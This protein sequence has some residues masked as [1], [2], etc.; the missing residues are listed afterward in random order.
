MRLRATAA[1]HVTREEYD[2][3]RANLLALTARVAVL[4]Q[5]QPARPLRQ[6]DLAIL[7]RLLP[8]L[9]ATY[10]EDGFTSRDCAEDDA[11]GL[12][13]V[14]GQMSV[15]AIGKLLARANGIAIDGLMVRRQR[16]EFQVTIWQVV[17]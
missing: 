5:R 10:G 8:V 7:A 4:E 2:A 16:M 15:K 14:V 1:A 6:A 3:L 13:L 17:A 12:R 9:G 11:P